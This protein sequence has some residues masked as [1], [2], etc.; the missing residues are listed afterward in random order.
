MFIYGLY[1]SAEPGVIRYVGQTQNEMRRRLAD[2]IR[3]ALAGYRSHKVSW[4]RTTINDGH[5]VLSSFLALASSNDE[6]DELERYY[7]AKLRAEGV[8]LTNNADGG[9]VNRGHKHD[10]EAR[11]N[12]SLSHL[13]KANPHK[14]VKKSDKEKQQIAVSVLALDSPERSQKIADGVKRAYAEGRGCK[15]HSEETKIKVGEAVKQATR[16]GR[17]RWAN[18]TPKP[19][20]PKIGSEEDSLKR[21]KSQ[22]ARRAKEAALRFLSVVVPKEIM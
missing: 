7:I 5:V 3:R 22:L 15:G 2:H 17:G 6:A 12:M 8:R 14:G 13:G 9:R 19:K 11:R 4:I 21:S 10:A 20:P 16:E 18:H 1:S